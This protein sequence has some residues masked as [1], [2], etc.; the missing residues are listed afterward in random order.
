MCKFVP[1]IQWSLYLV[2]CN[3]STD[4]NFLQIVRIIKHK[5]Y[6]S[7]RNASPKKRMDRFF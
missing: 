5:K 3:W 6:I 2:D 4:V 1:W 7:I